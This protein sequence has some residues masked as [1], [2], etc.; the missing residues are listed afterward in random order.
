MRV[1]LDTGP[2]VAAA[3]RR[4]RA[5]Q[6]AVALLADLGRD[7]LVPEPVL[8]EAD[9]FLR[10]R[11]GPYAGRALL[12][13]A[14]DG[15]VT[16]LYLTPGLLRYAAATDARHPDLDLGLVDASVMAIAERERLPIL[17]FDF[18]DFRAAPRL[19]GEPWTLLVDESAFARYTTR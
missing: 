8:A 16:V 15:E 9:W 10:G 11:A 18:E 13:S 1:V 5:H 4:D 19:N 6:L 3:I 14:A 17:T 12:R 2:L 7:A